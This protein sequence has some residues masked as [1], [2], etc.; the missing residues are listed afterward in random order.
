MK[1]KNC[2]SPR[3]RY[4]V[5]RKQKK[6]PHKRPRGTSRSS[7]RKRKG[8]AGQKGVKISLNPRKAFRVKCPACG[9]KYDEKEELN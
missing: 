4:L 3:A 8:R 6:N 2:G 9:I 7:W 1:C 5:S